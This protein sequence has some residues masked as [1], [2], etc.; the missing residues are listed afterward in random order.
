MKLKLKLVSG[1]PSAAGGS[2][3]RGWERGAVHGGGVASGGLVA[4]RALRT[5]A[6]RV[7]GESRARGPSD[8]PRRIWE[9]ELGAPTQRHLSSGGLRGGALDTLNP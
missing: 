1:F 4:H 5:S 2:Q 8:P 6:P 9:G 7:R 3:L